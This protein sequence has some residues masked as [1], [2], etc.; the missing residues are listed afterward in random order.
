MPH[1]EISDLITV[2]DPHGGARLPVRRADVI[3]RLHE[4]GDR[5]AARIVAALPVAGRTCST[6]WPWIA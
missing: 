6:R 1:L 4:A 2:T 5:R 3:R